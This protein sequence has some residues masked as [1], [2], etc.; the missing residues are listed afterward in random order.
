MAGFQFYLLDISYKI[1]D[2]VP[3]IYLFGKTASNE[4]VCVVDNSFKPY[5]YVV[6][7][8]GEGLKERLKRLSLEKEGEK[9]EVVDAEEVRKMQAEKEVT[10][11]KVSVNTP[12]AVPVLR[13]EIKAWA[14]V[15]SINEYDILFVRRYLI[16]KNITP[17]TLLTV[18]GEYIVERMRVPVLK[19]ERIEPTSDDFLK[20]P[21]ILALDI[22][23]YGPVDKNAEKEN[24]IVM[25]GFYARNFKK[26]VTWKS[27][28]ASEDYI[29][30]VKS[31][32]DLILRLKEI[33]E[34]YSPDIITGYYSD[35]FD[36]PQIKERANKY[37]VKLDLGLDYSELK[38]SGREFKEAQITGMV[39]LDVLSFIRRIMRT[40]IK[41]DE[42]TLNSVASEL[43][44]E[45]KYGVDVLELSSVWDKGGK[46]LEEFCKYNLHDAKLA[47]DLCVKLFS[48]MVELVKIIGLPLYDITRMPYS[49]LVEAY[50][51]R[52]AWN[53]NELAPNRPS[54]EERQS[55]LAKRIKGAFVYEPKPGLYKDIAVFDY[56]S[57]YP[58][59]IASHNISTGSLN[60]SCCEGENLVPF[61][62]ETYW[63]CSKKK[64]FLSRIIEDLI[65]RRARIKEIM[66]KGE[67]DVFLGARSEVLKLLANSFYGYLGFDNARWYSFGCAEATT[68]WGRHYI[69]EVI[70]KAQAEGFN[71]LY[72][73]TD[74]VFLTLDNKT[75]EDAQLFVDKINAAL[76]GLMELEYEG[77][78]PSGIFVATKLGE[79][80]KKKYAL[81][82]EKGI[83]QIKGFETVRRNWSFIAKEVQKNVIEIVLREHDP[84]KAVEYVRKVVS[85]LKSNQIPANKVVIYTQLQKEIE[86]YENIGPHVAAAQRM[87]NRGISVRPGSMIKFV[88]VK[89]HG[90]IRDK[91][92]LAD[93]DYK[94]EYDAEYYTNNQV[95]PSVEKIF[96]VLGYDIRSLLETEE[97]SKL[98]SFI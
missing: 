87:K 36:F 8:K 85:G 84:A 6:P 1:V 48:N 77:F 49:Q 35:G 68:A 94:E 74:S 10:V 93:E 4:K 50:I 21:R 44:G 42:F 29:E 60:C 22:E 61:E 58:T 53:A 33:I 91:V 31:E 71:V 56:R 16:D 11:L 34:E 37:R 64:G 41:T 52:Q 55:R 45:T 43:L 20:N 46:E 80:A 72:S 79:G 25:A 18:E 7:K 82:D 69:K 17:L 23:T 30:F 54:Y 57:L 14:E 3:L 86:D 51:L 78:Y 47:H 63:F 38:V 73:D 95:Y 13:E 40:S 89:G 24:P 67:G 2:G 96:S 62:G 65:T 28:Q 81:I 66:K 98:G 32:A 97:Q 9:F 76:P 92:R 88:V 27:F 75:K 5:F 90:R 59:I 12:K 15:Q 39:H 70:A 19:A 26:V 83:V